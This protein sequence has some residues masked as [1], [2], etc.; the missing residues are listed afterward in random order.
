MI[1][2]TLKKYKNV[3]RT[4]LGLSIFC[5]ILFS[6]INISF[7]GDS[8]NCLVIPLNFQTFEFSDKTG[9]INNISSVEIEL[10]S[11]TWDITHLELNFTNIEYY[12]REIM[13]I[14]DNAIKDDIFLDKQ[15]VEG[16]GV[17]IELNESA[18]IFG[19]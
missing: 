15:N 19:V 2:R 11:S 10:P 3:V 4:T 16:L 17:Q 1:F 9:T 12:M 8:E 13:V 6:N 18:T 7:A 14:E 5:L